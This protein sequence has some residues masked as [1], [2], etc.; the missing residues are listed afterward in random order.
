M[1]KQNNQ[2]VELAM[3]IIRVSCGA[4]Y[5]NGGQDMK[6]HIAEAEYHPDINRVSDT[7]IARYD[8]YE[9]AG[10]AF[11]DLAMQG[12][13]VVLVH[14]CCTTG[15]SMAESFKYFDTWNQCQEEPSTPIS[16]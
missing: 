2:M 4:I 12:R 11:K 5:K 13:A 16:R 8:D 7:V 3:E 10:A 6:Y 1:S 15:I 9:R 14:A